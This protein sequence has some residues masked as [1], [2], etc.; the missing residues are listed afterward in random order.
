MVGLVII[1]LFLVVTVITAFLYWRCCCY[2]SIDCLICEFNIELSA[3]A[4][5]KLLRLKMVGG[6]GEL[7]LRLC[8]ICVEFT[9]YVIKL[10]R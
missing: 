5:R 9:N 7:T 10:C 1:T 2:L 3:G 4:R 6:R 8:R